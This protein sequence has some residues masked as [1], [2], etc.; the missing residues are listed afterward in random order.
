MIH[1]KGRVIAKPLWQGHFDYVQ[2]AEKS[3]ELGEESEEIRPGRWPGV[4]SFK[5]L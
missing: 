3:S 4:T 5:A 2:R 1:A